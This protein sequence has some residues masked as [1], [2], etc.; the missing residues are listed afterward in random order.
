M[1]TPER[2]ARPVP[3]RKKRPKNVAVVD[4]TG[5]TGCEACIVFCPVD[6]IYK[7]PGPEFAT[8]NSVVAV[9]YEACIG[10]TLCVKNC[11]WETISMVP[12]ELVF[13]DEPA[14]A[15]AR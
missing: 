7:V 14:A 12:S 8:V 9:D 2:A 3:T 10:C 5:C 1:A 13:A 6:C 4:Q 15:V 11:P